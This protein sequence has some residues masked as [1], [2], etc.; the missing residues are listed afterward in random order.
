M[1]LRLALACGPWTCEVSPLVGGAIISLARDGVP[2][3]RPTPDAV[4]EGHDVRHTACYPLIPYANRIANG[5]FDF[6]GQ[7]YEL[8]S[9]FP[10]PHTLHGVGWRRGWRTLRAEA[11]LCEIALDHGPDADWPFDFAARQRFELSAAGLAVTIAVTNIADR[12]APAGLG[13][14]AFFLRRPG[15][16]L[17]FR[18]AGAWTN[19]VD[20]LP[21]AEVR[22]GAWDFAD[23][24]EIVEPLDNDFFGWDGAARLSALGAAVTTLGADPAFGHLR[25]YTPA[26]RDYYAVEPVTHG[27]DAI[28]HPER[29]GAMAILAPGATLAAGVRFGQEDAA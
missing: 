26:G 28:N 12:P 11:A 9:N 6:A 10:G 20:M 7:S 18:S 3:L 23:G 16:R 29:P 27:A 1:D 24:R 8:A 4:V 22:G 19:G 13:L 17:A 21:A 5:R 2:V 14:H 15:E 25:V